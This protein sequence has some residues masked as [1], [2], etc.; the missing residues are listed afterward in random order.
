MIDKVYNNITVGG[1]RGREALYAMLLQ[2]FVGI[3]KMDVVTYL[4]NREVHQVMKQAEQRVLQ[5]LRPKHINHWWQLD[6]L[7]LRNFA[8]KDRNSTYEYIL[9]VIDIFSKYTWVKPLKSRTLAE[10]TQVMQYIILQN[11]APKILHGDNEFR[12]MGIFELKKFGIESFRFGRAYNSRSQGQVERQN[13]II[14]AYINKYQQDYN[15]KNW[16]SICPLIEANINYSKHTTTKRVP[17]EIY[18]GYAAPTFGMLEMLD[19]TLEDTPVN[20]TTLREQDEELSQARA[21]MQLAVAKQINTAADKMIKNDIKKL[22]AITLGDFVRISV[23]TKTKYREAKK[24]G[25]QI[26]KYWSKKIFEVQ[27]AKVRGGMPSFKLIHPNTKDVIDRY[28]TRAELLLIDKEKLVQQRPENQPEI[29]KFGEQFDLTKYLKENKDAPVLE[30]PEEIDMQ[31]EEDEEQWEEQDEEPTIIDEPDPEPLGAEMAALQ[32]GYAFGMYY[33]SNTGTGSSFIQTGVRTF[34]TGSN[35]SNYNLLLQ[36]HWGNVGIGQPT[37]L[38]K[39][40]VS[41]GSSV[42]RSYGVYLDSSNIQ[43]GGAAS[44]VIGLLSDNSTAS[45]AFH[46]FSD[47]RIKKNI[48]ELQDNEALLKFRQ[49]KPCKYNYIDVVER[50]SEEVYGFI[51]QEVKDSLPYASNVLQFNKIIPNIYKLALY[52]DDVIT[53][54]TEHNLDSDGNIK[55]ILSTDKE[56]T[57]PYTVVDTLTINIDTSNL[58]NDE[59]PSNDLVQDDDGNDLAHN[60]FVYGTEVDDFHT[61]NKDAIWTTAAAALQEVDRIQQ[62]H[63]IEIADLSARLLA[64]ENNTS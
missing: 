17:F 54:D 58:S 3:T 57:C 19:N 1:Y 29:Y 43:G 59:Q 62:A 48:I 44:Y 55:L 41:G 56:I 36:P 32:R 13:R 60:I 14:R 47:R 28:Y 4:N 20:A 26:R 6:V 12:K 23:F 61:L 15:V 38:C 27:E 18:R 49:L 37:P 5:P 50:G 40:H 51:A 34:S 30:K 16:V 53:F 63:A 25:E 33:G 2:R 46:T 8:R 39:L 35:I 9:T 21:N 31:D 42:S 64:L 22:P 7:Y 10:I 11:G 52:N 24:Q 45:P